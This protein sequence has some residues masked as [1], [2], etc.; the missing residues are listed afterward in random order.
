MKTKNWTIGCLALILSFCAAQF[1][2][3][4][5][6]AVTSFESGTVN[7]ANTVTGATSLLFNTQ[8]VTGGNDDSLTFVGGKG[9][10]LYTVANTTS[11]FG[12]L[13]ILRCSSGDCI[14]GTPGVV[15]NQVL[16]QNLG[17][18]KDVTLD[19]GNATAVV[20]DN[21]N[22]KLERYN[23]TTG[24]L[25]GSAVSFTHPEGVAYDGA[26]HLWL[27][28]ASSGTSANQV[29]ELDPTTFAVLKTVALPAT[30]AGDGLTYDPGTDS[31]FIANPGGLGTGGGIVQI[32][33]LGAATPTATFIPQPS[34]PQVFDGIE[35]NLNGTLFIAARPSAGT[36][37]AE[38]IWSYNI[39]TG[40]F[41]PTAA[42]VTG[43]DDIAPPGSAGVPEPSYT[44]LLGVGLVAV[45]WARK[46]IAA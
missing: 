35:S 15:T 32:T 7:V 9:E 38:K 30:V 4:D 20:S 12:N 37:N 44:L 43:L 21:S 5:I 27:V 22:G 31:L 46:R 19:P 11:T 16:V 10:I 42:L 17:N 33:N 2:Q 14:D 29:Q 18:E 36:L 26:G 13:D 23:L 24:L 8:A 40:T 1:A 3:A 41:A 45:L 28:D 25:V 39:A 6:L 34:N